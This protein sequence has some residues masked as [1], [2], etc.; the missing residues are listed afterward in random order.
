LFTSANGVDEGGWSP[1]GRWLI[2]RSGVGVRRDIVGI[3]PRLDR[4]AVPLVATPFEEFSP[5]LSPDGRWIAYVSD[6]SRRPEVYVRPFPE[7]ATARWQ[8]SAAGGLEPIWGHGGRE[9]YYRNGAGDLVVATITSRPTFRVVSQRTLFPA[10]RLYAEGFH[11]TYAVAPDGRFLF[12]EGK[13]ESSAT[14]VRVDNW[15]EELKG[16]T[17]R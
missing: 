3:R 8:V 17:P 6:Q 7:T 16:P 11:Q 13:F 12:V 14:L 10:S 9:L 15:L 4:A 1:D 2:V 5:A